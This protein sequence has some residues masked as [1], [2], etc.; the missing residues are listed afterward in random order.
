MLRYP[1]RPWRETPRT[2]LAGGARPRLALRGQLD[3]AGRGCAHCPSDLRPG[4]VIHRLVARDR[5]PGVGE[6]AG[7]RVEPR[8]RHQDVGFGP[9]LAVCCLEQLLGAGYRRV[10]GM[11]SDTKVVASQE[12]ALIW[13]RRLPACRAWAMARSRASWSAPMRATTVKRAYGIWPGDYARC[14]G[15]GLTVLLD[16]SSQLPWSMPP[17]GR[18]QA[19]APGAAQRRGRTSWTPASGGRSSRSEEASPVAVL[20]F[21]RGRVLVPGAGVAEWSH[22]HPSGVALRC[23]RTP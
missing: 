1:A 22:K 5:V 23:G 7:V 18:G 12:L 15:L 10:G 19:G 20:G 11:G 2:P 17:R 13:T 9:R 16:P 8:K 21:V 14:H 4:A 6:T 3:P